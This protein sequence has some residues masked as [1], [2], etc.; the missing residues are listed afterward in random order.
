MAFQA[1]FNGSLFFII[2]S[3]FL[4]AFQGLCLPEKN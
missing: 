1:F 3:H 4:M 2:F